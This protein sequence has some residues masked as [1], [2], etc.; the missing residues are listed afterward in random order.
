MFSL[1]KKLIQMKLNFRQKKSIFPFN[2][3]ISRGIT[4]LGFFIFFINL[5]TANSDD[6]S[7]IEEANNLPYTSSICGQE[8][9][10]TCGFVVEG[11]YFDLAN[12]V[13]TVCGN[14]SN[15]NPDLIFKYEPPID[16]PN[17]KIIVDYARI[18]NVPTDVNFSVMST[19]DAN[20]CFTNYIGTEI[21]FNN[22]STDLYLVIS[23]PTPPSV[24]S[25]YSILFSCNE[26]PGNDACQNAVP[27]TIGEPYTYTGDGALVNNNWLGQMDCPNGGFPSINMQS[28][29]RTHQFTIEDPA[30]VTIEFD[31]NNNTAYAA[32]FFGCTLGNCLENTIGS[33]NPMVLPNL[34]PGTYTIVV[35]SLLFPELNYDLLVTNMD[36]SNAPT[37]T[38]GVDISGENLF[39]GNNVFQNNC[40]YFPASDK[41]YK[42]DHLSDGDLIVNLETNNNLDLE[43]AIFSDCNISRCV[44]FGTLGAIYANAPAGTYYILVDGNQSNDEDYFTLNID[45]PPSSNDDCV[46]ADLIQVSSYNNCN[47]IDGTTIGAGDDG[48]YSC[49]NDFN[50]GVWYKFVAP[51]SGAVVYTLSNY[52]DFP[53]VFFLDACGGNELKCNK[54]QYRID[55]LTAGNTYFINV[56]SDLGEETDFSLCLYEPP[57]PPANDLCSNSITVPVRDKNACTF[58][59]R[60]H[61]TLVGATSDPEP[62]CTSTDP[63]ERNG[64]WYNFE[65]PNSGTV[66][67]DAFSHNSFTYPEKMVVYDACNGNEVFCSTFPFSNDTIKNLVGG[68]TYLINIFNYAEKEGDFSFCLEDIISQPSAPDCATYNE[69]S[70]NASDLNTTLDLTW[71]EA[72]EATGYKVYVGTDGGGVQTPTD[73]ENGTV[74]N[75]S[76]NPS[77]SL[78]NLLP[79]TIYY[80]QIIPI[81]ATGDATNCQIRAFHTA[82]DMT[83]T[84]P[85]YRLPENGKDSVANN[86]FLLWDEVAVATGYKIYVGTDGGGIQTPSDLISGEILDEFAPPFYELNGLMSNTIYYWQIIPFDNSGDL[87]G[88]PI[89]SFETAVPPP[90]DLCVDAIELIPNTICTHQSF[91]NL[92]SS[93]SVQLPLPECKLMENDVWFKVMM[94]ASGDLTIETGVDSTSKIGLFDV[95]MEVY[96][97]DCSGGLT[98]IAC[99]G[100]IDP[101]PPFPDFPNLHVQLNISNAALANQMVF[102]RV[103]GAYGEQGVFNLC[104]HDPSVTTNTCNPCDTFN[105]PIVPFFGDTTFIACDSIISQMDI[106]NTP[107]EN[108]DVTYQSGISITLK[109]G[110]HVRA[111]AEFLAQI[112]PCNNFIADAPSFSREVLN[113]DQELNPTTQIKVFPNPFSSETTIQFAIAEAMPIQLQLLDITGKIVQT[114]VPESH[115]ETGQYQINLQNDQLQTGIYFFHLSSPKEHL[116]KKV[117]VIR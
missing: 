112:A 27:L 71:F 83:L 110:F 77:F 13:A 115:Y 24:Y 8:T 73:F 96:S 95:D 7:I 91:T 72:S 5:V 32:V 20:T 12:N 31:A 54:Y 88:C 22:W 67:L 107:M 15:P 100:D 70:M 84:C 63:L 46:D 60:V 17:L 4:F 35:E 116:V 108:S 93:N 37:I 19:C 59:N 99:G 58:N 14:V 106:I 85:I 102:I 105:F 33:N 86:T 51:S 76:S 52:L 57:V 21:S 56:T 74:V 80:W 41:L 109:P 68:Q 104:A 42:Y 40:N 28:L 117:M 53:N 45:C 79:N 29:D 103:W 30:D 62:S 81:N 75:A 87:S 101:N 2:F 34:S 94:P 25:D 55:G 44:G 3:K 38:C 48:Q 47:Q 78:T 9:V 36:C 18:G 23:F 113:P 10:V 11:D 69:P 66:K 65:A 50:I 97:G 89:W 61:G 92:G 90:N 43:V 49:A 16:N 1:S 114:I 39:T 6:F 98:S 111:G 82:A 26:E 64:V